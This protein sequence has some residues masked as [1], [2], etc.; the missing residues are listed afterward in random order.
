MKKLALMLLCILAFGSTHA[1]PTSIED[2]MAWKKD[3]LSQYKK[4]RYLDA[5]GKA[6]TEAV[7]VQRVVDDRAAFHWDANNGP[8]KE[9]VIRLLNTTK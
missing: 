2:M 4:V 5:G 8:A 1:A 9:I 6:I 7:F 3:F